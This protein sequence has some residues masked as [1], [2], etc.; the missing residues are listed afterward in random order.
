M[1]DLG[2]ERERDR[3]LAPFEEVGEPAVGDDDVGE[4]VRGE[5]DVGQRRLICG[6]RKAELEHADGLATIG[7]RSEQAGTVGAAL[8]L[9]RL[10]GK[11]AAMRAFVQRHALGGLP[12]LSAPRP[13]HCRRGRAGPGLGRCSRRGGRR[14]RRRRARP[15]G[16]RRARRLR[17]PATRSRQPRAARR[18]PIARSDGL[19][20]KAPYGSVIRGREPPRPQSSSSND[21][22][23]ASAGL[24]KERLKGLE[25]STFCMASRRSSQ[26]SYSRAW[27][28]V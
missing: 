22:S 19:P 3:A 1:L 4:S 9:D 5:R 16:V 11:R 15:R 6:L 24:S 23:P 25:P 26:L 18:S 21:E 7:H 27:R 8:D 13:L 28:R 2:G 20:P 10:T 12:P 14:P 17:R